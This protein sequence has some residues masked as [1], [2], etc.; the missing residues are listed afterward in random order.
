[1]TVRSLSFLLG[2]C[3]LALAAS[4]SI[5]AERSETLGEYTVHYN[6]IPTTALNPEI[7]RRYAI[8]RSAGR[9]LINIAVLKQSPDSAEP[10]AVPARIEASS[11]TLTGQRND[12]VLREIREQEAIYY[13]GDFRIRG[14]ERLRF[15]LNVTPEGSQRPIPIRFEQ[16]LVGD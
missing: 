2:S 14:E 6:A 4:P 16:F 10:H 8:T 3:V 5:R 12:I 11:R 13:I 9:A 7:A 15:E 1:M